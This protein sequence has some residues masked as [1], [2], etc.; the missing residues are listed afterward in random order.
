MLALPAAEQGQGHR[1]RARG[2]CFGRDPDHQLA[3]ARRPYDRQAGSYSSVGALARRSGSEPATLG[4][5]V[6][7]VVR[8]AT[9]RNPLM[10][11]RIFR[12]RN[13]TGANIIQ[14]L[15]VAGMFGMFFLGV[16][17][18]Q[19]VL[20]YDALETGLAFLPTTVVIG[21]LSVRYSERLIMRFGAR[22]VAPARPRADRR[23]ARAVRAGARERRLRHRRAALDA[24]ARHRCRRL[25]QR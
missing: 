25:L 12:S 5:L 9:A 14:S 20:G 22:R 19:R 24:P 23:R 16:L 1:L 7:F 17:Y 6:A 15:T 21:T 8:E 11:L 18:L 3:Y 4:L 2:R 13:V 10:P